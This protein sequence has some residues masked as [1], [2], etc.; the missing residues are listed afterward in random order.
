MI[1]RDHIILEAN[2]DQIKCF[3]SQKFEVFYLRRAGLFGVAI[4]SDGNQ[5]F[6]FEPK[7]ISLSQTSI[8][9]IFIA[10]TAKNLSYKLVLICNTNTGK[11][12][13]YQFNSVF[14]INTAI[15]SNDYFCCGLNSNSTIVFYENALL[16]ND[17][18][19]HAIN[20]F[21]IPNEDVENIKESISTVLQSRFE[22][23]NTY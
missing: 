13:T 9:L 14:E 16:S 19:D 20:Q 18:R 15:Q 22:I 21:S 8:P 10:E 3:D 6:S 12:D 7:F 11:L 17:N 23:T 2:Y 5:L 4:Y 1:Y